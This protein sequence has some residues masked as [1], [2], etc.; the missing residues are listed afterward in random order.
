M[1]EFKIPQML[2][3]LVRATL[4]HVKCI[5]KMQN[6][7]S[8]P[9]GTSMGL[10][11]GDAL[12]CILFNLALEKVVRDSEIETKETISSSPPLALQPFLSHSLP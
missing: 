6:N 12:S 8:E 9:F 1:K 4:K 2:T 7:V 5:F 11:Q 10:R 3:G